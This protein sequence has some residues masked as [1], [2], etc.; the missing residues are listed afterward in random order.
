MKTRRL[1]ISSKWAGSAIILASSLV[2]LLSFPTLHN[3]IGDTA[4]ALSIV[5]V[6]AAGWYFGM[7]GGT[8]SSLIATAINVYLLVSTQSGKSFNL[9]YG[10]FVP[11][12]AVL[13]LAGIIAGRLPKILQDQKFVEMDLRARERFLTKLKAITSDILAAEEMDT[14]LQQLPLKIVDLFEADDCYITRW[15]PL[16]GQAVPTATSAQLEQ[17][18]ENFR[19]EPGEV[20]LSESVLKAGHAI[21]ADDSANSPFVNQRIQGIFPSRSL[22]GIPLVVGEH[23]LGA[24]MVA[25]NTL[26]K[27][28]PIELRHAEQASSQIALALWDVQQDSALQRRLRVSTALSK[29]AQALSQTERVGLDHVLQLIVDSAQELIPGSERAVLHLLDEEQQVL[30]PRAVTGFDKPEEGKMNMRLGEGVA[31]QVIADGKSINIAD[32]ETDLR[33]IRLDSLPRFRSL[34]VS[35]VQS[36]QERIG[37]ISVQSNQPNAFTN[38]EMH[39][40]SS[41]GTQASL[42]IENAHL[43]ETT[44]QGLK[45]VNAL[46]RITQ[47]LVASL[48]TEELMKE[49]VELLQ[50]NFGYS[51]VHIFVT[52]FDT[53]NLNLRQASGPIGEQLVSERIPVQAGE[54]IIGHAAETGQAFFTNNVEDVVFYVSHPLLADTR[55]ELAVPIIVDQRVM[56]VLDV[57]NTASAHFTERDLQLVTTVADQLAVA[58]QK[59]SLY[60]DLQVSLAQEK[61]VRSQ[62]VQS[63][64]LALV[65]RLLASV[66]HELN[67]PLQA[68]QNALF[69]L[70]EEK[71]ISVQGRQDLQIVLSETERMAGLI[72]RLRTSYRSTRVED[73]Q[74]VQI[75]NVVEDVYALM[76]THLRHNSIAFEFHPDPDL[77]L[78]AGLPDQIRQVILNLLMNGSEAMPSGGRL[79]VS[80]EVVDKKEV[81]LTVSDTGPGIEPELLPHI[82]D[83]FVT[84]KDSGTGLGLTI[85]YDIIHHHNGRIQAENNPDQGATFKIWFPT[86]V[87]EDLS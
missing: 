53:G 35:P 78:I 54:G 87:E 1:N 2:Y 80:T 57:Q 13:F 30:I 40:L 36:G 11:G 24:I 62:L 49:V 55:S 56:G 69:L 18:Y 25:F 41:L 72:E 60:S 37:T 38:D 16:L 74:P 33:F 58:L 52:D 32:V 42:A 65:G 85:T 8:I 79:I 59:A 83:A 22:L 70:Q 7:A 29:I 46:F 67:N 3:L 86:H 81:L 34:M 61:S 71:D 45:E 68:I 17:P 26:H 75:N 20:N 12:I 5:P 19:F 31:G 48:D 14:V 43:L 6:V 77:P 44:Q 27:F 28:T 51:F 73:L 50:Q 82:F 21:A 10:G 64:R 84:S 39:L 76:S 63:E 66:S 9:E 47:G 23:K 15:D 4:S